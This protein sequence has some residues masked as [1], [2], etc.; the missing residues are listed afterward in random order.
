[1]QR[2]EV[3]LLEVRLERGGWK[4]GRIE[5]PADLRLGP[6]QYLMAHAV[7][8]SHGGD[9]AIPTSL[10]AARGL[11]LLADG[12]PAPGE[13]ELAPPLPL[14][15]TAGTRLVLR[16]PLG[17]GF[18]LPS[19]THHVGLVA[20]RATPHRL[21]PLA[22]LALTQGAAVALYTRSVPDF[23]PPEIEVLPLDGL[24]E[25][26][27]WADFFAFDLAPAALP[28]LKKRFGLAPHTLLPVPAQALV[29]VPMPC[30]GVAECGVCAVEARR[31]YRLACKEG[32]VFD[33]N[34]L[35][36]A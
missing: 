27:T 35:E 6:G 19:N 20:L 5:C 8:P 28:N 4:S 30:G 33:L 12:T 32:P 36:Q 9:E 3:T 18:N 7:G 13:L 11:P 25:A 24:A 1:M 2:C 17:R 15:W 26:L 10:F 31:G 29:D 16:G 23:L 14:S 34:E 21:L 22:D